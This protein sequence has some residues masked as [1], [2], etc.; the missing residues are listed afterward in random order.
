MTDQSPCLMPDKKLVI[1][2][3][4]GVLYPTTQLSGAE[5]KTAFNKTRRQLGISDEHCI[6]ASQQAKNAKHL[7]IFN[8]ILHICRHVGLPEE[9]FYRR[10]FQ[11]IDYSR[12]TPATDLLKSIRAFADEFP[13]CVLTNNHAYHLAEILDRRFGPY[14]KNFIIPNYEKRKRMVYGTNPIPCY[15]ITSTANDNG[16]YQ[17]KQSKKGFKRFLEKQG[18]LPH[19]AILLDDTPRIVDNA[20][21]KGLR[22]KLVCATHTL[23]SRLREVRAELIKEHTHG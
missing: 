19:N 10:C 11:N 12:I 14:E 21:Q 15:D 7:G 20:L 18:V 8:F 17:P 5:M 16:W 23:E 9:V 22:A 3:C 6:K 1:I 13:V 4:D 2:D